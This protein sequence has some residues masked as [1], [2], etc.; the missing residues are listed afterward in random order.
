MGLLQ[1]E[2][3]ISTSTYSLVTGSDAGLQLTPLPVEDS[4][5]GIVQIEQ[6]EL[7]H[8]IQPMSSIHLSKPDSIRQLV[9]QLRQSLSTTQA[10]EISASHPALNQVLLRDLWNALTLAT[11]A[12]SPQ[13][14][15]LEAGGSPLWDLQQDILDIFYKEPQ[16]FKRLPAQ[17]TQ[18]LNQLDAWLI[19]KG[20]SLSQS[21]LK[22]LLQSIPNCKVIFTSQ[23]PIL[24]RQKISEQL[25]AL[26][27]TPRYQSYLH[28][29]QSSV[30]QLSDLELKLLRCLNQFPDVPIRRQTLE[31]LV[32]DPQFSTALASL[33][34]QNWVL[35]SQADS[36]QLSPIASSCKL[37]KHDS[38]DRT[39]ALVSAWIQASERDFS[40]LI[41][42]VRLIYWAIAQTYQNGDW[43]T[44]LS[45]LRSTECVFIHRKWWGRWV[46]LL[47]WGVE[48]ARFLG[49]KSAIAWAHHQ[50]GSR[51]LCLNDAA[52]AQ[53]HLN[54]AL[55]LRQSCGDSVGAAATSRHVD[56]LILPTVQ[57]PEVVNSASASPPQQPA[58]AQSP[59]P[60]AA[61]VGVMAPAL[62]KGA[63][64][65]T[66]LTGAS[67][68]LFWLGIQ[69]MQA[70]QTPSEP[71]IATQLVEPTP[72]TPPP[73]A[74]SPTVPVQKIEESD[75]SEE[76]TQPAPTKTVVI[77]S[78]PLGQPV[79]PTEEASGEK[80]EP[81]KAGLPVVQ[82]VE[83]KAPV[84]EAEAQQ[85]HCLVGQWT[86]DLSDPLRGDVFM[87][88]RSISPPIAQGLTELPSDLGSLSQDLANSD[89]LSEIPTSGDLTQAF[90]TQP[91]KLLQ[92]ISIQHAATQGKAYLKFSE[93]GALVSTYEN[94]SH[95]FDVRYALSPDA[96]QSTHTV[97][98]KFS[99]E[100]T[101]QASFSEQNNQISYS[102]PQWT[103]NP[104]LAQGQT[105]YEMPEVQGLLSELSKSLQPQEEF[106]QTTYSCDDNNLE[107]KM[108]LAVEKQT[109]SFVRRYRR[110]SR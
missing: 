51:A 71:A 13:L 45:L 7:P 18:P 39:L 64:T 3:R 96:P 97:D 22:A 80:E 65:V 102:N 30:N 24:K 34:Q 89:L 84:E 58:P 10:I 46:Q 87:G 35:R 38:Q 94:L 53:T 86:S 76:A 85:P 28:Q 92:N 79:E 109:L 14:A 106:Y 68:G 50:L 73:V 62:I 52:S 8:C 42:E 59:A 20:I 77:R 12:S 5:E 55:S 6:R 101:A 19:I 17:M 98:W 107:L 72:S 11:A 2:K 104:E 95:R 91:G 67:G 40:D 63:A 54:R 60:I 69:Q 37:L 70:R 1:S 82:P 61:P 4:R 25:S 105:T 31:K 99:G 93:A 57:V 16:Q 44:F 33:L 78:K 9:S 49:D 26:V 29:K 36:L 47:F 23:K 48:A 56:L 32:R 43:K 110:I 90:G 103:L 15:Y 27:S 108:N 100:M 83:K 75:P 66:L 81:P 74:V 21:D 41:A 88:D